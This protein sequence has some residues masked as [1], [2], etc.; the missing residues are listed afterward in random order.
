MSL[1][2]LTQSLRFVELVTNKGL[3]IGIFAEMTSLL[4]PRL[5]SILSPISLFIACLFVFNRMLTDRELVVMKAAGISPLQS[6]KPVLVVGALLA[7]FSFYINNVSI[8][9][10][11]RAFNELE[12][13]VKND[14]SHLFFREGEFTQLQPGLTIFITSQEKDGSISGIIVNDERNPKSKV[15]ITAEKGRIV[16]IDTNPRII[17]VK[18]SRQEITLAD[19]KFSSLSFDRYS[20][21]VGTTKSEK[22]KEAEVRE[23]SLFS[24]LTAR[25]NPN[26]SEKDINRFLIEGNKRILNPLH[27]ILF[28]VLGC[29]GLLI[30]SFNRRGQ[31]KTISISIVLLVVIQAADLSISS[32]VVKDIRLLPLLYLNF[33]IPLIACFYFILFYN[34]AMFRKKKKYEEAAL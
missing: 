7:M 25:N 13:K 12:W 10:A 1:L 32:I 33:M 2:W 26:L 21:D 3:P 9:K 16:N 18:G 28:A 24:L 19:S 11:E 34:P 31:I 30:G 6:I 17:M 14:L 29:V 15:T 27:N 4:M 5:F 23:Q 8:P 20:I 22:K